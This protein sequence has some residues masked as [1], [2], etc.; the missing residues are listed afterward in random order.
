MATDPVMSQAAAQAAVN[1]IGAK[2]NGGSIR[3]YTGTPPATC[4]D[5]ATGTLLSSGCLFS[6]TAFAS[7]TDGGS[8][9][10]TA[11]ANTISTDGAP[12]ADGVAGY[13]RALDSSGNAH[14]QGTCGTAS[15]DMIL[16]NVTISTSIGVAVVSY[17]LNLPDGSG[18]D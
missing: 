5:S 2:V 8:G 1:A 11:S 14:L 10:A 17:A 15:S 12:V 9:I 13:F 3:I 18:T 6:A 7:A 4:E 16:S